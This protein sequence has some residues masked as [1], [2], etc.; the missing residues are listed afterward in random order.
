VQA[1]LRRRVHHQPHDHDRDD[2]SP[3]GT[4]ATA[5]TETTVL[6]KTVKATY[7]QNW[8]A[9][10]AAQTHEGRVPELLHGLCQGIVQPRK[11]WAGH[12]RPSPT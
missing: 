11:A 1:Y 10:N 6:T 7:K 3:D 4:T 2:D 12:A 8:P 9:Y 5:T